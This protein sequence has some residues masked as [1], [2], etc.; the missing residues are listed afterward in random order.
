MSFIPLAAENEESESSPS[1]ALQRIVCVGEGGSKGERKEN[2]C[3]LTNKTY[4]FF[5]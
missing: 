4:F 3:F 5:F 1:A 2:F